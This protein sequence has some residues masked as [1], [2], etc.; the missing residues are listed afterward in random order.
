MA[1][2]PPV[3]EGSR[4]TVDALRGK[5]ARRGNV[6][7]HEVLPI[8]EADANIF[9][10]PSCSR[11][12]GVGTSRCPGCRTRLISGIRA[13]KAL[14]FI[15]TGLVTGLL[16]GGGG[17]AAVTLVSAPV[18]TVPDQPA[19]VVPSS[20]PVDRPAASAPAPTPALDPAVPAAAASAL[21]QSALLNARIAAD[22]GV[23]AAALSAD[24][25]VSVDIARTLR[26]LAASAA[27]GDRLAPEVA[28]W[29]AGAPLS[30]RL[31]EFY[32]AV[33]ATARDALSASV[34]NTAAYIDAGSTMLS[35]LGA[36]A[37]L[38]ADA[39][40]LAGS[41]GIDLPPV[42]PPAP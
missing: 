19:V 37:G 9:D 20:T 34:T 7:G 27:V 30:A 38:D 32:A 1:G 3:T 42:V 35:V 22:A 18:G 21:R 25:P 39:R 13:T 31:A 2:S 36:M 28:T 41:A 23:L 24:E 40:T 16:I 11:P 26:A 8:G 14:G 29:P 5:S 4:M 15:L 17:V 12:L 6:E 33:G 10:C